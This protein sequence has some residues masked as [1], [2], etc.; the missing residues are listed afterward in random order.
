MTDHCLVVWLFVL[1]FHL[2]LFGFSSHQLELILSSVMY[3][4]DLSLLFSR[5]L[6]A[7]VIK[8]FAL[9]LS[10]STTFSVLI[11]ALCCLFIEIIH[12]YD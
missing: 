4:R 11:T 10:G 7:S 2:N 9:S 8:P 12:G 1:R 3:Q 5:K 6:T